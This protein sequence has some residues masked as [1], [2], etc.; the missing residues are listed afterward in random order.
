[1]CN[2]LFCVVTHGMLP[3]HLE[4]IT[5][6]FMLH[7]LWIRYVNKRNVI[8]CSQQRDNLVSL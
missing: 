6:K 3:N 7:D 1:M 5:A 4:H 8:S 2:H